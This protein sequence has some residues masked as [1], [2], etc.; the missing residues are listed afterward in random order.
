MM[1]MIDTE[2]TFATYDQQERRIKQTKIALSW[3]TQGLRALTLHAVE[4]LG[5]IYS[6]LSVSVSKFP[7][8]GIHPA[9]DHVSTVV[10]TIDKNLPISE[11]V[12]FKPMLFKSQL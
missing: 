9:E 3:T 12:Q 4:N 5:I 2:S 1:K 11:P 8:S 6:Y 10:C 7:H